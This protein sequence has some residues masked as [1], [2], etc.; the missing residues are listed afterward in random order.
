MKV[1]VLGGY[2]K[3][4]SCL[5]Q[6]LSDEGLEVIRSRDKERNRDLAASSDVLV[7]AVP[8]SEVMGVLVDIR[9][10]I[11]GVE[12][13]SCSA[14]VDLATISSQVSANCIRVMCDPYFQLVAVLGE[15]G[16]ASPVLEAL[17][18]EYAQLE[19]DEQID[20]FTKLI[21]IFFVAVA[22]RGSE[23]GL[24]RQAHTRLQ[25][26]FPNG[27]LDNVCSQAQSYDPSL[28]RTRGGISDF[29]VQQLEKTPDLSIEELLRRINDELLI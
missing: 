22:M 10:A 11:D 29:I 25:I 15:A 14:F 6:R 3:L 21:S 28:Y 13:V 1:G 8:P 12:V 2:G 24:V 17:S 27:Q 9:D 20:D 16:L 18:K 5:T 7:L 26:Y 23:G 19:S 4:G